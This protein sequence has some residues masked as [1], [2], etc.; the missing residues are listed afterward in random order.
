M[1][2][3]YFP[4]AM[5]TLACLLIAL[6][7]PLAR[8]QMYKCVDAGGVTSYS[9]SPHPGCRTVDIRA[10]PPISGALQGTGR[11][12]SREDAAFRRRQIDREQSQA[13]E[14]AAAAEH[15]QECEQVR[16]EFA[17]L[18]GSR[19]V[20]VKTEANGERVFM[21]DD[22]RARRIANLRPKLASCP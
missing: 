7:M 10:Q 4:A 14:Q 18:E 17:Q 19:R 20:L 16:R 12:L 13:K 11:D 3:F 8:A 21:D 6:A 9:D 15:A 2:G 5:R 1:V 22:E